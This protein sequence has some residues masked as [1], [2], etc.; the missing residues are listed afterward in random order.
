MAALILRADLGEASG[1]RR[2]VR[3]ND[4]RGGAAFVALEDTERA[5]IAILER[6]PLGR[7]DD[8]GRGEIVNEGVHE[9]PDRVVPALELEMDRVTAI[10]YP[11]REAALSRR[12]MHEGS[13]SDALHRATYDQ[14][15]PHVTS[16]DPG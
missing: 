13:E 14:T 8:R 4:G 5:F 16:A 6:R 15:D 12:A 2:K 10:A 7:A 3:R 1:T 9:R 11:S